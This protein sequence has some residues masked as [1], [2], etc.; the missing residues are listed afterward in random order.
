MF[1]NISWMLLRKI[2]VVS[3]DVKKRFWATGWEMICM[4]P[5]NC[6]WQPLGGWG[7]TM[8]WRIVCRGNMSRMVQL[9]MDLSIV[10]LYECYYRTIAWFCLQKLHYICHI[11]FCEV[12]IQSCSL[13]TS[14]CKWKLTKW[15]AITMTIKAQ[16]FVQF[17]T[18]LYNH[19]NREEASNQQ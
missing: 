1:L 10:I 12:C 2:F 13:S 14:N 6:W 15:F 3:R 4:H 19:R 9:Q 11:M 5:G 16:L 7:H 8:C 18:G 17:G